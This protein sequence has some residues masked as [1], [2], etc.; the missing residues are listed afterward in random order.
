MSSVTF[1]LETYDTR[2]DTLRIDLEQ[3][4]DYVDENGLDFKDEFLAAVWN[5]MVHTEADG[6]TKEYEPQIYQTIL[7]NEDTGS[8]INVYLNHVESDGGWSNLADQLEALCEY[9]R[10]VDWLNGPCDRFKGL[11]AHIEDET[12]EW[13][14]ITK[15][16]IEEAM[17]GYRGIPDDV[18]DVVCDLIDD[19]LIEP[20]PDWVMADRNATIRELELMGIITTRRYGW[21]TAIW[22]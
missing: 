7:D 14:N 3:F 5:Y 16:S 21:Y 13:T 12:W 11:L 8:F 9:A 10:E 4:S 18:W 20:I 19:G 22:S 15:D 2:S 17:D 1:V 6:F